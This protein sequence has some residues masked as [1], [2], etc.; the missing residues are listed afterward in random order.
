[1]IT[2]LLGGVEHVLGDPWGP[3][4]VRRA[5]LE[6]ALLGVAAGALG[7]WVV[8]SDLAY[9]TESL[10]H[11]LLPGLVLA[12]L[13]GLPL[14]IGGAVGL[15]VAAGALAAAGRVPALGRDA[16]VAAVVTGLFGLGVLLGLSPAAPANLQNL[17]FGDVLG[18][19]NRDLALAAAL[20]I[21]VALVLWRGH[22][23]LL[24]V[25]FD[26]AGVRALGLSV[27]AAEAALLGL[28]AVTIL[29]AVPALGTLLVL[30][31]VLAPAASAR[32]LVRRMGPAIALAGALAVLGGWGGL[33]LS[34]WTGT[35]AGASVAGVLVGLYLGAAALAARRGRAP[36]V[37]FYHRSRVPR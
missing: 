16:A 24:A 1:M 17:L 21:V 5:F 31:V 4:V 13:L 10:A 30:A 36:A 27:R 20:A 7:C 2:E 11:A 12:A 32:L 33:Y 35:A 37:R 25:G 14:L 3:E 23:R 28:L 26:P 22:P 29:G 9:T 19:G 34:Y 18:V 15:L 8:L 6:V